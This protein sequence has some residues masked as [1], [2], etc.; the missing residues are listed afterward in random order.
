MHPSS[1]IRFIKPALAG[2]AL[3]P[4]A[5]AAEVTIT[6][7]TRTKGEYWYVLVSQ[8]ST[9]YMTPTATPVDPDG[10]DFIY[11]GALPDG[12]GMPL[13]QERDSVRQ[14]FRLGRGMKATFKFE[15]IKP[16]LFDVKFYLFDKDWEYGS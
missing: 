4:S 16:G 14:V 6:S 15:G 12:E 5:A 7:F 3:A 10:E 2:L 9:G 13:P 11:A 8:N 1:L